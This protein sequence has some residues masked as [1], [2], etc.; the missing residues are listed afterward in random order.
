MKHLKLIWN[1]IVLAAVL[2]VWPLC[3]ALPFILNERKR[4]KNGKN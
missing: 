3:V 1:C 2:I 4:I